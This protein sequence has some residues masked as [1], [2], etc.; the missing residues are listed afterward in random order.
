VS[1][2][3]QLVPHIAGQ[4]VA[5]RQHGTKATLPRSGEAFSQA[6]ALW[7][8][9]RSQANQELWR[10]AA[11]ARG[12]ATA[13][14]GN[15]EQAL[16]SYQVNPNMAPLGGDRYPT[17]QTPNNLRLAALM[18][19]NYAVALIRYGGPDVPRAYAITE[20]G[21]VYL[22]SAQAPQLARWHGVALAAQSFS[23]YS[24]GSNIRA[25]AYAEQA[26]RYT[27]DEQTELRQLLAAL[28]GKKVAQIG[29]AGFQ[30]S[31]CLYYFNE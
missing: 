10:L 8:G 3:Q 24:R 14:A 20:L 1:K 11:L 6:L 25:R 2:K 21:L 12:A 16:L 29:P 22:R 18:Y 7:Q 9:N 31:E 23:L 17:P 30:A 5:L 15:W 19:V 26:L 13:F 27:V 4:V 28:A